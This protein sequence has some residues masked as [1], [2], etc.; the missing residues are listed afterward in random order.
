MVITPLAALELPSFI[1]PADA[2]EDTGGGLNVW[3]DWNDLNGG[4][5][6]RC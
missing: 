6:V 3:K 1:L 2:G 4:Y 5:D